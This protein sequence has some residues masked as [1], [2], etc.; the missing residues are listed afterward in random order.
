MSNE[1]ESYDLL[2]QSLQDAEKQ[3]SHLSAAER[4]A[5]LM[6]RFGIARDVIREIRGTKD[7]LDFI[8]D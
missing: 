4:D 3:L 1:A 6:K 2:L 8:V 7:L 5:E